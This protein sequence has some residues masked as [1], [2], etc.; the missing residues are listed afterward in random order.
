MVKRM[1]GCIFELER[2]WRNARR[3]KIP[4]YGC[5]RFRLPA[6]VRIGQKTVTLSLPTDSGMKNDFIAIFVQDVYGLAAIR[7]PIFSVLDVGANVGLFSLAARHFW[8]RA[9]VHAYEPNSELASYIDHHAA[10]CGTKVFYEAVGGADG[11]VKLEFRDRINQTRSIAATD[12]SV[13][14]TSLNKAIKRIAGH[15]DL[16][17]LDCEGAEWEMIASKTP[18]SNVARVTMEY[19][20]RRG[21]SHSD[22]LAYFN[23]IG[24]KMVHHTYQ[25]AHGYGMA[26]AINPTATLT[27]E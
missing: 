4:F 5:A 16:L 18:W 22:I 19:H 7:A 20:L 15:V 14:Q 12:G 26:R 17:K 24:F 11:R 13:I 25:A 27:W 6:E 21:Q 8:P 1:L 9:A 2:M 3:F 23:E 10:Q